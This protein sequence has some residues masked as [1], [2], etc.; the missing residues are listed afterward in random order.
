MCLLTPIAINIISDI[1]VVSYGVIGDRKMCSD[2]MTNFST[3]ESTRLGF[4]AGGAM[5]RNAR[6]LIIE[7]KVSEARKEKNTILILF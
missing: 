2:K 4:G 5:I 3:L 6:A 7:T 1:E